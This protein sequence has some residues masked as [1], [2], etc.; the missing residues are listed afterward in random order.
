M[1][2]FDDWA[3]ISDIDN[4]LVVH[5]IM[6]VS[7]ANKEAIDYW[8]SEGGIFTFATGRY[9]GGALKLCQDLNVT[10]PF[11]Y[12]NGSAIYLPE[13]QQF[14]SVLHLGEGILSI[15]PKIKSAFPFCGIAGY[16][17]ETMFLI[18]EDDLLRRH[19]KRQNLAPK[20]LENEA[21]LPSFCKVLITIES[22]KMSDLKQFMSSI[23][24]VSYQ[25]SQSTPD[26]F[27]I[28][29]FGA[30]KG[31]QLSNLCQLLNVSP[32]KVIT[33]GDNENDISFLK[34]SK[35]S[36]AVANATKEALCAAQHITNARGDTESA[37]PEIIKKLESIIGK[38]S[39]HGQI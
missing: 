14:T 28:T 10:L 4:T 24:N 39:N 29:P 12:N 38:E 7:D 13:S 33:V 26:F 2:R 23:H 34:A 32:E 37:F 6:T 11:I 9:L 36:F 25:F 21:L 8:R 30:T 19:F 27:E 22:E 31:A 15:L 16:N 3:I 35:N 17:E 18:Q 5:G 1:G 20:F